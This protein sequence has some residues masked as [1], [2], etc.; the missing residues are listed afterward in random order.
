MSLP[1]QAIDRVAL[2]FRALSD[3]TRL[4]IL[5]ALRVREHTVGELTEIA[6]CSQANISKHLKVLERAGLVSRSRDAQRR[7]RKLEPKPLAEAT[8]WLERYRRFWE[9]SFQHLD[10]LLDELKTAE[11]KQG[12]RKR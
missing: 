7:P 5:N 2:Y 1:D 3:P 6:R 10:A 12:R 4:R 9:G 11:K 8:V